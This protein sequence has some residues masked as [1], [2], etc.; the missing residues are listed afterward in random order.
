MMKK[1]YGLK[2]M[3]TT[4]SYGNDLAKKLYT[5]L[6]FMELDEVNEENYREIDLKLEV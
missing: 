3:T 4:Y 6:G 1:E 5:N 2:V